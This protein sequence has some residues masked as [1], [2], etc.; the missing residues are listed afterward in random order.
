M[1]MCPR[2]LRI[3]LAA[4][5]AAIVEDVHA[6]MRITEWAYASDE[7]VEFTNVGGAAISMAG[8]HYDDD[9]ANPASGVDLSAF[10]SVQPGESVILAESSAATFR[11]NWNLCSAIK[12]IGGNTVGLGRNDQINL[13]DAGGTLVD[14]LTYGDQNFAGSIRTDDSSGWVS[15]A[16]LGVDNVMAWTR[17]SANDA[18]GSQ[19]SSAAWTFFASPGRSKRA[20]VLYQPCAQGS[21]LTIGIE[22]AI[23]AGSIGDAYNPGA[24]VTLSSGSVPASSLAIG[25]TS[26]NPAVIAPSGV[27]ITG[28][29]SVRSLSFTPVGRGVATLTLTASDGAGTQ[30]SATLSYAASLQAPDPSAAYYH[31]IG[32]ASGAIDAGD[33][34]VIL[35]DDE[36]NTIHL[37][38]ADRTGLPLK[39]W[40]FT[41]AQAGTASAIDFEG[42]ARSD[43]VVLITGSH[44]NSRSGAERP[45]RR[46][47]LAA[48]IG[49]TGANTELVFRGRYNGLWNELRNWDHGNGHGLGADALR[50]ITATQIGVEPDP[51][52]GFNIEALEFAPDGSTVYLGFRAPLV[53]IDGLPQALI[54]PLLNPLVL[55][56]A[57]PGS[58]PAQFGAPIIVD[59]GGRTFRAIASNADGDYL[60]SAGPTPYN[61]T[62]ALYSWDGSAAHAPQF[63]RE[64]PPE[65]T[66]T[67]GIWEAIGNVPHPLAEGA[68]AR[69]ITDSGNTDY[70]GNGETGALPVP[71]RKSYS[72]LITLA[73]VPAADVI[74]ASGFDSIVAARETDD[75]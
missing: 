16:G 48:T 69:M 25:I 1:P 17:S 72:Q 63:N 55:T 53:F 29:D 58:G 35:V 43:N 33:G 26:S 21:G 61:P 41:N 24:T 10:G 19:A 27:A 6:Q 54:V 20:A 31:Y 65:D 28:S 47:L 34:H 57:T 67:G 36:S 11:S 18:E 4:L 66:L 42:I 51:P 74:F 50:F 22:P 2:S 13:F 38:R 52:D 23:V 14:R 62:W 39:T 70:Y 75:R 12:V 64:L 5:L 73:A 15:A 8:W 60:I 44:G 46:T 56:S 49:G 40:T 32:E 37:H 7:F 59:L 45:E 71:Y 9:S 30:Q 68:T 3:A